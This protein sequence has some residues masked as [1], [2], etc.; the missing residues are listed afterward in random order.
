MCLYNPTSI[1]WRYFAIADRRIRSKAWSKPD[2]ATANA[3]FWT[4]QGWNGSEDVAVQFHTSLGAASGIHDI[5]QTTLS[6]TNLQTAI[7]TFQGLQASY[8]II[9]NNFPALGFLTPAGYMAFA[10]DNIFLCIALLGLVRLCAAPWLTDDFHATLQSVVSSHR[11]G[12]KTETSVSSLD[13]EEMEMVMIP[14]AEFDQ[15]HRGWTQARIEKQYH[16][17][18]NRNCRAMRIAAT[19]V[20][21]FPVA[22][23]GWQL[24]PLSSS[25][26]HYTVT[27]IVY[28]V[29]YLF[30][31]LATT[32]IFIFHFTCREQ[33][34]TSTTLPCI[35]AVWY[36]IYTAVLV[37]LAIVLVALAAVETRKAPC[38]KY[39]V[40]T[41]ELGPDSTI[42]PGLA[43]ARGGAMS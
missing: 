13:L 10:L 30:L 28:I 2:L 35:N 5:H 37:I 23:S 20:V 42:C 15:L 41:P 4:S 16:H 33:S 43:T 21:M 9:G 19:A 3:I 11:S 6:W 18:S 1:V 36:K 14:V 31:T 7:V 8:I 38:G 27:I 29:F 32:A 22:M 25:G 40:W 12:L 24:S 26:E 17:H 34:T 39:T